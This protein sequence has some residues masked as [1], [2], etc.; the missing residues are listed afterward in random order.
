MTVSLIITAK[1]DQVVDADR[2]TCNTKVSQ[3]IE[4]PVGLQEALDGFRQ[5]GW[6]IASKSNSR[7]P[8]HSGLRPAGPVTRAPAP[9]GIRDAGGATIIPFPSR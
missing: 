6:M 1:C 5:Q 8:R 7:C 9:V 4:S 2:S 3:V